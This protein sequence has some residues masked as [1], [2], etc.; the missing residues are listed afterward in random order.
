MRLG[1]WLCLWDLIS[2]WQA[3]AT[4]DGFDGWGVGLQIRN[5][6]GR[7]LT[8]T[9]RVMEDECLEKVVRLL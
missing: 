2:L 7:S 4:L 5:R 1:G 8:P 9:A 3:M 6:R